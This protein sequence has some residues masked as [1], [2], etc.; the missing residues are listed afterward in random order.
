MTEKEHCPTLAER[1]R[2][3]E[4]KVNILAYVSGATFVA[5]LTTLLRLLI[6]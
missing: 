1:V 5:V 4:V 2:A 3:L 6:Q